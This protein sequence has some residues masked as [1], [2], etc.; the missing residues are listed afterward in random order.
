MMVLH[1]N[2]VNNIHTNMHTVVV[3][4]V[5]VVVEVEVNVVG[6]VEWLFVDN[7]FRLNDRQF[8]IC[9]GELLSYKTKKK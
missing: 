3:V 5:V 2:T 7:T 6:L 9:C 4:V 8:H 1:E